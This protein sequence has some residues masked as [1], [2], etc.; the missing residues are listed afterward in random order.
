MQRVFHRCGL[1]H[2]AAN[3]EV[4]GR[5]NGTPDMCTLT[6]KKKNQKTEKKKNQ[7]KKNQKK[8]WCQSQLQSIAFSS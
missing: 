2:G 8:S 4:I 3:A 1:K 7:K 6:V 5:R